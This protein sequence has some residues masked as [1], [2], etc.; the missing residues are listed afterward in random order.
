VEED[1]QGEVFFWRVGGRVVDGFDQVR[2]TIS[3]LFLSVLCLSRFQGPV[4]AENTHRG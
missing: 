1:D 4:E 2:D 3:F